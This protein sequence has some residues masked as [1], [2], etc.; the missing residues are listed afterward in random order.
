ME[1]SFNAAN[2]FPFQ[3]AHN[4]KKNAFASSNYYMI[5]YNI[6]AIIQ[7]RKAIR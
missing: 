4:D 7:S 1:I 3:K 5:K 6:N 2:K